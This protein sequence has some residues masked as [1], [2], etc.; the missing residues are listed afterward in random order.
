MD[1]LADPRSLATVLAALRMYSKA[2]RKDDVAVYGAYAGIAT[3]GGI[4]KPL[5]A[6]EVDDLVDE[7]N[8]A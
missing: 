4:L 2:L 3:D 5:S 8:E 1:A 7:L 6:D